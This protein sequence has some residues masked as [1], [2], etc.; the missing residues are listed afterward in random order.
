MLANLRDEMTESRSEF[1]EG[2]R[3]IKQGQQKVIWWVAGMVSS[4]V[5]GGILGWVFQK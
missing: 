1:R 5:V 2:I 4:L 3:E